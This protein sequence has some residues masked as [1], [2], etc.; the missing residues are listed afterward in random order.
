MHKA[1]IERCGDQVMCSCNCVHISG[2]MEIEILHR[3]NLGVTSTGCASLD[4]EGGTLR[5]LANTRHRLMPPL[6]EA[7][8]QSNRRRCLPLTQRRWRN[9]RDIDVLA[10]GSMFTGSQR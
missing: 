6:R 10:I 7:L 9:C 8:Y 1:S 2:E 3:D 5:R 4:T